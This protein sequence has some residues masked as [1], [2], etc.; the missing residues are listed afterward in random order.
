MEQ[1]AQAISVQE[2]KLRLLEWSEQ[3][4]EEMHQQVHALLESAKAGTRKVVPWAAGA[5]LLFGLL[6]GRGGARGDGDHPGEHGGP[7]RAG[8]RM[9][10]TAVRVAIFVLPLVKP[11]FAKRP[12]RE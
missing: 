12:A 6:S 5:A 4:D 7:I 10:R 3:A 1:N 8:I 9:L 2:A 11:F